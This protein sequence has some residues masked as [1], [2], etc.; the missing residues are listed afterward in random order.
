MRGEPDIG[1]C[2]E[3]EGNHPEDGDIRD[4]FDTALQI[5]LVIDG[6]RRDDDDIANGLDDLREPVAFARRRATEPEMLALKRRRQAAEYEHE[7]EE[8]AIEC[9][10]IGDEIADGLFDTDEYAQ[11]RVV[12]AFDDIFVFGDFFGADGLRSFSSV[13]AHFFFGAAK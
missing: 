13:G 1:E 9:S 10:R 2:H 5:E 12:L 4:V 8:V 7:H 11:A 3:P 6:K